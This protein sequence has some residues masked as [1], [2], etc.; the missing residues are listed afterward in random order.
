[1]YIKNTNNIINIVERLGS[2]LRRFDEDLDIYTS[3]YVSETVILWSS[4]CCVCGKL[5]RLYNL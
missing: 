5:K 4:H 2:D 3:V 1:M